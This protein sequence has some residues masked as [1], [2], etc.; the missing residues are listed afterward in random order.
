MYS[1]LWPKTLQKREYWETIRVNLILRISAFLINSAVTQVVKIFNVFY[2]HEISL[3][4]SQKI[5]QYKYT[6]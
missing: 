4:P 3:P 6:S 5:P 2:E 1:K